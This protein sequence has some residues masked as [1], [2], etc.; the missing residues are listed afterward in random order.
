[1]RFDSQPPRHH[2]PHPVARASELAQGQLK[3]VVVDG[4]EMIVYRVGARVCAAQ[5]RC[6]HQGA[7]LADGLLSRGAIVCAL[8][9]WRFDAETGVHEMSSENCLVTYR[10]WIEGDEIMIDTTPIRRAEVP[11]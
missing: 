5:R 6:L 10:A 7:D 3:P 8:H 1:M 2:R 9:G 11:Q 4:I